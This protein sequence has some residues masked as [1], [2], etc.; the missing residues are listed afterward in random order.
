MDRSRPERRNARVVVALLLALVAGAAV[1]LWLEPPLPG[2]SRAA[3][4][5]LDGGVPVHSVEIGYVPDSSGPAFS[6][7]DCVIFE[8]GRCAWRPRGSDVRVM[9]VGSA[10]G[11]LPP[12][13]AGAVL[14]MLGDMSFGRGLDLSRVR[15]APQSD[16]RL[17]ESAPPPARDLRDL[18]TRKGLL[19]P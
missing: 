13:Q 12:A 15:L 6:E 17:N 2:W 1:L 4:E 9:L 11:D 5:T 14:A 3:Q 10:D 7:Y 8:D 18:L 16:P 19:G